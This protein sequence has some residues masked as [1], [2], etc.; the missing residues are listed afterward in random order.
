MLHRSVE[1]TK[2]SAMRGVKATSFKLTGGGRSSVTRTRSRNY[3]LITSDT[4]TAQHYSIL[5]ID[6][7]VPHTTRQHTSQLVLAK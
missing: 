1:S 2:N 3:N 5:H 4:S 6:N 7:D